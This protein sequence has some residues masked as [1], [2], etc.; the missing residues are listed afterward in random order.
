LW[1]V[2]ATS[3]FEPGEGEPAN[4]IDGDSSTFWH[5]RW[6]STEARPPHWL[7]L[8]L[9]KPTR[10]ARLVYTARSESENGRIR[11][12]E[13]YLSD[14]GNTWG[15]PVATGQFR[16]TADPQTITLKQ[17]VTAKF[18]KLVALSEIRN[19]AWATIAELEVLED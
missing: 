10:V 7:I 11:S 4:A 14:D 19:R 16:G 1:K 9:G 6:S 3:S 5:T 18:L 2:V 8:D 17:P 12:Y 13:I 15:E